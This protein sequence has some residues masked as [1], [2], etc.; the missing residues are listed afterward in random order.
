MHVYIEQPGDKNKKN[1]FDTKTRKLIDVVDFHITY[2]YPYGYILNTL[3]PDG[4]EL[5]CYIITKQKFQTGS[6]IECEPVGM[7]EWFE[8]EEED[9]KILAVISGENNPIDS[10]VIDELRH[11]ALN[12]FKDKTMKDYHLGEYYGREEAEVLIK[13]YSLN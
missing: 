10:T 2:P 5:D 8:D 3:S 4:Q 13:K 9:H 1:I 11:F 7:I 6:I 12:F